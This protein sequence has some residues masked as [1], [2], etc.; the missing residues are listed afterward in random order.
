MHSLH[1]W[2]SLEP[3]FSGAFAHFLK[4][5]GR[6]QLNSPELQQFAAWLP[7][8]GAMAFN[9]RV[10]APAHCCKLTA[11]PPP[12]KKKKK[13]T[14]QKKNNILYQHPPPT[15]ALRAVLGILDMGKSSGVRVKEFPF[16]TLCIWGDAGSTRRTPYREYEGRAVRELLVVSAANLE[17]PPLVGISREINWKRQ[18]RKWTSVAARPVHPLVRHTGLPILQ[19]PCL[20]NL[21]PPIQSSEAELTGG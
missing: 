20:S 1:P 7:S 12:Q 4:R 3:L 14:E 19:T 11:R 17:Q 2:F 21:D 10:V 13:K 9:E 8:S 6:A 16:G 15:T 5:M 18:S